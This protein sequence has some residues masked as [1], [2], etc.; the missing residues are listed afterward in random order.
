MLNLPV[1]QVPA[2]V[3]V[4]IDKAFL[5]LQEEECTRR[6]SLIWGPL[7]LQWLSPIGA[8]DSILPVANPSQ[9]MMILPII[10]A[11]RP[12]S[13][14]GLQAFCTPETFIVLILFILWCSCRYGPDCRGRTEG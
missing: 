6:N 13:G 7:I 2:A 4:R 14:A 5:A 10:S 1:P 11:R 9:L 12:A 8:N 3:L